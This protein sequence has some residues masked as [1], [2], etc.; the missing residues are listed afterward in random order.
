[1]IAQQGPVF[2]SAPDGLAMRDGVPPGE[3]VLIHPSPQDLRRN[4]PTY[5]ITP[6]KLYNLIVNADSGA[7]GDWR[8]L[9]EDMVLRD[10]HLRTVFEKRMR[11]VSGVPWTIAPSEDRNANPD[12]AKE[13][14]DYLGDMLREC[15]GFENCLRYLRTAVG[16]GIAVA[17][18]EF[19]GD[20]PSGRS[21]RAR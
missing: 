19:R 2:I 18:K 10:S 7:L 12:R 9:W 8:E 3:G 20:T 13:V 21:R 15:E 6:A 5:G 1:M 17:E 11:G 14:A 4:Y 16:P